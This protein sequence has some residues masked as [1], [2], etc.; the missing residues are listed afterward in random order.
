MITLARKAA[1]ETKRAGD[2]SIDVR[3]WAEVKQAGVPFCLFDQP[4]LTVSIKGLPGRAGLGKN[5][6]PDI[7][8]NKDPEGLIL[9]SWVGDGPFSEYLKVHK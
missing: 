1:E 6:A 7:F 8:P 9:K 4:K 5:H 2:V 3:F